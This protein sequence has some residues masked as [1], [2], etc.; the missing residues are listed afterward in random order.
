MPVIVLVTFHVLT[1]INGDQGFHGKDTA[2]TGGV[3]LVVLKF[4]HKCLC[5]IGSK[6]STRVI[7]SF[8]STT[9]PVP[10]QQLHVD[11]IGSA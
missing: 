9:R 11:W 7:I 8:D 10:K 3:L 1:A 2:G 5:L 4:Q 6:A